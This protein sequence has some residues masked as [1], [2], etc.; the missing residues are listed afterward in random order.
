METPSNVARGATLLAGTVCAGSR[1][2]MRVAMQCVEYKVKM[3]GGF[4]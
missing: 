1:S 2:G 3:V 4:C